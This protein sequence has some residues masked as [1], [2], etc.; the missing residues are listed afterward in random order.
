MDIKTLNQY[1][2]RLEE[3]LKLRSYPIGVKF[4]ESEADVPKEAV[5]PKERFKKHMAL[6]QAFSYARMKGMTIAMRDKHNLPYKF[7]FET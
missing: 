5:Y 1:G 4:C 3:L 7:P 6:C 2:E